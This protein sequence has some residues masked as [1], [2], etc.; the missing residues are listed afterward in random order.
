MDVDWNRLTFSAGLVKSPIPAPTKTHFTRG[1]QKKMVLGPASWFQKGCILGGTCLSTVLMRNWYSRE[2][3][4]I[5]NTLSRVYRQKQKDI[6]YGLD[7]CHSFS[8]PLSPSGMQWVVTR[9]RHMQLMHT[10]SAC[11]HGFFLFYVYFNMHWKHISWLITLQT[12]ICITN[13]YHRQTC[14]YNVKFGF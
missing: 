7:R 14:M 8:Q 1:A 9:R 10:C 4:L 13:I 3:I 5:W 12:C 2:D 11:D 6:S